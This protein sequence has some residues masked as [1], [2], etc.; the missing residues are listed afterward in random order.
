MQTFA[1]IPPPGPAEQPGM[2]PE[3]T[4]AET[5]DTIDLLVQHM[6]SGG[7]I[8]DIKGLTAEHY[9]AMYA[10]GHNHYELGDIDRAARMFQFLVTM[11]PWDRR[12]PMAAGAAYQVK[13][14]FTKALNYYAMAVTLNMMDPVALFHT[15]ECLAA[16]GHRAEACEALEFVIKHGDAPEHAALRERAQGILPLLKAGAAQA[17]ASAAKE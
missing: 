11:N 14:E 4:D 10:I 7:T 8:G 6:A 3:D 5:M 1:D 17:Q 16:L 2:P 9:E 15:A 13:G 12:F